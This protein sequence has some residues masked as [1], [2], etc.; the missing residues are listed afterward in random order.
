MKIED[1]RKAGAELT[2][3][4]PGHPQNLD[5]FIPSARCWLFYLFPAA[6][7]RCI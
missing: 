1:Q 2:E 7:A 6:E 3:K 5:W 4:K